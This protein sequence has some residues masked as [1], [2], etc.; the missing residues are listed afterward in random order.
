MRLYFIHSHY[1][2]SIQFRL[3]KNKT[4]RYKII[5]PVKDQSG[6]TTFT[7]FNKEVGLLPVQKVISEISQDNPFAHIPTMLNN[8][9]R[10]AC[11]FDMKINHFNTNL[12]YE[13]Y[14]VVKLSGCELAVNEV[15]V[16]NNGMT[17]KRPRIA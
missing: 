15:G 6:N 14:T 3:I 7:L 5:V 11:A 13:E 1:V 17:A 12:G 9:I 10:K 16:D 4:T 8:V 2:F